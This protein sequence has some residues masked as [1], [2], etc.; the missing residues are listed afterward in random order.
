MTER[1]MTTNTKH[2][3]IIKQPQKIVY[4]DAEIPVLV[5]ILEMIRKRKWLSDDSQASYLTATK[6]LSIL[7]VEHITEDLVSEMNEH[8]EILAKDTKVTAKEL[9]IEKMT[10][11]VVPDNNFEFVEI[12]KTFVNLIFALF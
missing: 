3:I 9:S 1:G 10:K 2:H 7:T 4:E 12:I 5:H 8:V 11:V 6:G